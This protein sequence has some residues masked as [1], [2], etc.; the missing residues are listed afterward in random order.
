MEAYAA[1]RAGHN[2]II[3]RAPPPTTGSGS[4]T[5]TS[6]KSIQPSSPA[7][8]STGDPGGGWVSKGSIVGAIAGAVLDSVLVIVA[9]AIMRRR[10]RRHKAKSD[11]EKC[12]SAYTVPS[13]KA[14][15]YEPQETIYLNEMT[16]HSVADGTAISALRDIKYLN[17]TP[18]P[19]LGQA[20]QALV[21]ALQP[22]RDVLAG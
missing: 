3:R 15:T 12:F 10:R 14:P 5:S 2:T 7:D 13:D 20:R 22:S 18:P 8:S 19:L 9:L 4:K 17:A 16:R 1:S 21:P 6:L 11:P